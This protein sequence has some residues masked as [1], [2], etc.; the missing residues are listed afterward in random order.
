MKARFLLLLAINVVLLIAVLFITQSW[1]S[2]RREEAPAAKVVKAPPPVELVQV[3]TASD[4][5]TV[6]TLVKQSNITWTPWPKKDLADAF[7][8]K[9]ADDPPEKV[10]EKE[11]QVIGGVARFP[12]AKGQPI[13]TGLIVK[14]GDRGFLAAILSPDKRAMAISV[15]ASSGGAGLFMPGDRVDVIMTQKIKIKQP[16]ADDV[17]RMA[18]EILIPDVK[19]LAI[20][21]KVS[22][23]P[24]DP[25]VGRTAMIEVSPRQAETLALGGELG[26]LSLSLRS[27]QSTENDLRSRGGA[28]WDYQASLA[29]G[30]ENNQATIPE[31]IRGGGK[32]G[33]APAKN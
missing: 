22:G 5:L 25:K 30:A 6:G 2:N 15:T 20:D 13:V 33:E 23:D 28:M 11:N 14:P 31:I 16:G 27:L 17:E 21:Q 18:S 3:L 12:L 7:I 26:S 8:S 4:N 32:G 19:L 9:T 29:L 10:T 24:S 1:M